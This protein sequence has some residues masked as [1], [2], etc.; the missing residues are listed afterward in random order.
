MSVLKC[1]TV[2]GRIG[3]CSS[4]AVCASCMQDSRTNIPSGIIRYAYRQSRQQQ[5]LPCQSS[6]AVL[7]SMY[8]WGGMFGI[9]AIR[10]L[11][12]SVRY[13]RY[14]VSYG[15]LWE[16][17]PSFWTITCG[18]GYLRKKSRGTRCFKKKKKVRNAPSSFKIEYDLLYQFKYTQ[19]R[20]K[21]N[22]I[23]TTNS[24]YTIFASITFNTFQ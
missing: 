11:T 22:S 20:F 7:S 13:A 5:L 17:P 24:T 1:C 19:R 8:G 4:L 2:V 23:I 12:C 14:S 18:I 9:T 10:H 3:L 6:Y 16:L 21:I 15:S